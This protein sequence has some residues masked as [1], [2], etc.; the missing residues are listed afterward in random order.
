M[1]LKIFEQGQAAAQANRSDS[2][3]IVGRFRSGTQMQGRPVSLKEWRVTT[4]DPAVADFLA[5]QFGGTPE[6]WETDKD[7]RI[8]IMTTSNTVEIIFDSVDNIRTS[9]VLWGRKGKI[10]ECDGEYLMEDGKVTD[11]PCPSCPGKTLAELKEAEKR[12]DGCAPSIQ[13]YFRLAADPEL[14]RFKFFTGAWSLAQE[15]PRIEKELRDI[16]GPARALLRLEHVEYETKA[17]VA[18]S[19]T[20]PVLDIVGPVG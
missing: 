17:G 12:G 14:G 10:R 11:T 20:K 13:L 7:D 16:G 18:R 4:D 6:E 3:D 9:M 5:A 19:F 8:E 2:N 15:M 1:A